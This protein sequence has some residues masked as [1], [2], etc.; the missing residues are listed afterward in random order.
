MSIHNI[1]FQVEIRTIFIWMSISSSQSYA[2]HLGLLVQSIVSLRSLLVVK[3]LI[4]HVHVSTISNS[5]VFLLKMQK[6]LTIF[7]K[8]I[9]VYAI[10]NDQ[11]FN[12]VLTNNNVSLNNWALRFDK[13]ILISVK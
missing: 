4:V 8:N 10:F 11:N 5:Q 9:S 6:L 12:E 7:S 3:M 13:R 1:C 2:K